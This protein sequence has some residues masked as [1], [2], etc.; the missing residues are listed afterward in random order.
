MLFSRPMYWG[1][2]RVC[3]RFLSSP[4]SLG[5]CCEAAIPA[6]DSGFLTDHHRQLVGAL[7]QQR[8]AAIAARSA[9]VA[10]VEDVAGGV[11]IKKRLCL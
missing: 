8:Q 1:Y 3:P 11:T 7:L 2:F 5:A 10:H 9:E 6:L 4:F